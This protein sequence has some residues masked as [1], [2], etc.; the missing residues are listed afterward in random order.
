MLSQTGGKAVLIASSSNGGIRYV[1]T[2]RKYGWL[3]QYAQNKWG[4]VIWLPTSVE[5]A[6]C[7]NP[8]H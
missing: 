5:R 7:S 1:V 2:L 8:K 3:L 6:A 4:N